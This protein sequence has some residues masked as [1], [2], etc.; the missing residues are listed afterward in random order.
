M[1]KAENRP[2][3]KKI[4]TVLKVRSDEPVVPKGQVFLDVQIGG[5][6]RAGAKFLVVDDV[7]SSLLSGGTCEELN[8]L[9]V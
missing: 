7:P 3:L 9:S 2:R 1:A 8:M 5:K 6:R 4:R